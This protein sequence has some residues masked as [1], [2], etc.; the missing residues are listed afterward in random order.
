MRVILLFFIFSHVYYADDCSLRIFHK[1]V[2]RGIVSLPVRLEASVDREE[3]FVWANV[4]YRQKNIATFSKNLCVGSARSF[5]C[6]IP[7]SA[8]FEGGSEYYIEVLQNDRNTCVTNRFTIVND[9]ISSQIRIFF[10]S[11]QKSIGRSLHLQATISGLDYLDHKEKIEFLLDGNKINIPI[12]YGHV[13]YK[14]PKLLTLGQHSVRIN[15]YD[16]KSTLIHFSKRD[17]LVI[18]EPSIND[19]KLTSLDAPLSLGGSLWDTTGSVNFQYNFAGSQN[20][21]N[22][23]LVYPNGYYTI[24]TQVQ[25]KK[26]N[27]SFYIGPLSITSQRSTP[28]IRNNQLSI[29]FSHD[30]L[31]VQLGTVSSSLTAL[32]GGGSSFLGSE[33]SYNNLPDEKK[34]GW[35]IKAF[36]GQSKIPVEVSTEDD[37]LNPVYG[38]RTIGTQISFNPLDDYLF[39]SFQGVE[40]YDD[41]DSVEENS[42]V[43]FYTNR[44]LSM[45]SKIF[46]PTRYFITKIELEYGV[47][48]NR[49]FTP[50]IDISL[51]L[52]VFSFL[53]EDNFGHSLL[54][55][56][57]GAIP[58]INTTFS[59]SF[60][61]SSSSYLLSGS[62]GSGDNLSTQ[63]SLEHNLFQGI[64]SLSESFS[65][66]IDNLEQSKLST[67][68]IFSFT[69]GNNFNIPKFPKLSVQNTF[70]FQENSGN[71]DSEI[72]AL[73]NS[74]QLSLSYSIPIY[75]KLIAISFS[76][77]ENDN[78]ENTNSSLSLTNQ[79]QAYSLSLSSEFFTWLSFTSSYTFNF[80]KNLSDEEMQSFSENLTIGTTFSFW[81][82]SL[83]TSFSYNRSF[84]EKYNFLNFSLGT[85][86]YNL[87]CN[88]SWSPHSVGFSSS[89]SY[90]GNSLN[91]TI[92]VNYSANL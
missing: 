76:F 70:T 23:T 69:L 54:T 66:N 73:I 34:K 67:S 71:E 17:F 62:A 63:F 30:K 28:G 92:G 91:Y 58:K 55:S 25:S 75:S 52:D 31:N 20:N 42:T 37:T 18:E 43:R 49:V 19:K 82:I 8:I 89:F 3:K 26:D 64:W 40:F 13:D 86:T 80:T 84:Q 11:P 78:I 32:S 36:G 27:L 72:L 33:V 74:L 48:F 4:F 14:H 87:S 60:S 22:S 46:L 24:T 15:I 1:S 21:E 61:W 53:E 45:Q 68:R 44:L 29:G 83:P 57:S 35:K 79:T 65:F 88:F 5:S 38:Q 10:L 90:S 59:S 7:G 39:F 2:R 51:P 56:V 9:L 50:I 85:L 6:T 81:K 47:S 16:E 41:P 77:S 12:S